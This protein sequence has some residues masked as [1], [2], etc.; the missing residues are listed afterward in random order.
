MASQIHTNM[1]HDKVS[2][3]AAERGRAKEKEI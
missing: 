1:T 3:S 2:E